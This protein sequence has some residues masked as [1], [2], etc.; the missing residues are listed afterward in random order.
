MLEKSTIFRDV[1]G[2]NWDAHFIPVLSNFCQKTL[3]IDSL[4]TVRE[5]HQTSSFDKIWKQRFLL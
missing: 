2:I 1:L 5:A 4:L 3:D